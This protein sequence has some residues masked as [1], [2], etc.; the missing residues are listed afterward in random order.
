VPVV[1]GRNGVERILTLELMPETR[2]R[3]EKS[4][5]TIKQAIKELTE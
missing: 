5:S 1:L 3:L 2:K 4:V